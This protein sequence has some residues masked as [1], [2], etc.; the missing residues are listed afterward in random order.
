MTSAGA[1]A[2][3]HHAVTV[4]VWVSRR[5]GVLC[6]VWTACLIPGSFSQGSGAR[7]CDFAVFSCD[8]NPRSLI[9]K[10]HD[11][12]TQGDENLKES[13]NLPTGCTQSNQ[14]ANSIASLM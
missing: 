5:R 6:G 12:S 3:L 11:I 9:K 13:L 7:L 1:L 10:I 14:C 2:T 8:L 4:W